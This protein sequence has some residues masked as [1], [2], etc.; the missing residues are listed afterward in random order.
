MADLRFEGVGKTYPNGVVAVE[1]V[2]LEIG[3]GELVVLVGPSGCGKSTILRMVA[4]LEDVSRGNILIAGRVVNELTEAQR[5]IAMVFQSYALYPHLTV[6]GN[7]EFPLRIAGVKAAE[8]TS[9]VKAVLETVGLARHAH[10]KPAQLSGG[11]RQRVAMARAIIRQP[12]VFLMDEPLSN[13][14]AKLRVHVRAE[15][16]RLQR[17]LGTT[18]LYVT[19][20]QAE[21]MT[22][23]D[24]VVLMRDGKIQQVDSPDALYKAPANVFVAR[25]LGNPPMNLLLGQLEQSAGGRQV[26]RVGG[27]TLALLPSETTE[28]RQVVGKPLGVLIGARPEA[29]SLSAEAANARPDRELWGTVSMSESIGSDVFVHV[30][31]DDSAELPSEVRHLALESEEVTE[32]AESGETSTL[33]TVRCPAETRIATGEHVGI[34]VHGGAIHLFDAETGLALGRTASMGVSPEGSEISEAVASQ[35]RQ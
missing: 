21:A 29:L 10:Q 7:V 6:E 35:P 3:D 2:D 22:L 23:G 30:A 9:R 20:D 18:M 25:F 12:Q 19:H 34:T 13:L 28:N 26:V 24:R 1:S 5:D 16:L 4:G 11:Q 17:R 31:I 32:S 14:D 15:I 8:R 33:L 27:R